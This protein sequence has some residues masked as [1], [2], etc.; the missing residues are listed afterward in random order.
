MA[1]REYVV[2]I[3][4]ETGGRQDI[5]QTS[6][7]AAGNLTSAVSPDSVRRKK[8]SAAARTGAEA[9][10]KA[11]GNAALQVAMPAL[12]A[13]TDGMASRAV[14]AG[15]SLVR[16]GNAV[17]MGSLSGIAGIAGSLGG[18]AVSA[19]VDAVMNESERNEQRQTQ[20]NETNFI[21]QVAGLE[22]ISYTTGWLGK[23]LYEGVR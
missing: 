15:R 4:D 23:I 20:L 7:G 19:V 11:W 22:K 8:G 13:L 21:R 1:Y 18:M 5:P 14:G 12:N 16:L 3:T 10:T 6:D 9:G 17:A 2:R